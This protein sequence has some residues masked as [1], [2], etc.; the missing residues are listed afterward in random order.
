MK[1]NRGVSTLGIVIV[2]LIL[3]FFA[4][5]Y[6]TRSPGSHDGRPDT[7]GSEGARPCDAYGC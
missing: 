6:F 2:I 4:L 1:T 5:S 7:F 3:S